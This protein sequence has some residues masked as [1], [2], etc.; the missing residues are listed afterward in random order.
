MGLIEQ[1]LLIILLPLAG[2]FL[3]GLFGRKLPRQGD[4]LATGL[5]GAS[6]ALAV[7]TFVQVTLQHDPFAGARTSG[8]WLRFAPAEALSIGI[9]VDN[10]TA[11]MLVVVGVVSFLVHLYSMGYMHG[12]PKYVRFYTVLQLFTASM[13]GLVL[14]DNL[15][16]LYVSWELMGL[17]S[18]LLIGHYFEKPSAAWACLKA[19]MTTR[20]G[21]VLMFVGILILFLHVGS[22]R[23]AD[24]FAAV[25]DGRLAGSAQMW[26]GLLLFGG[27][28]GK[29]AQFPLHIWL[30]DAME[31]PTPV[32]ALIHAATMVAAGVYLMARTYLLLSAETFLVVAYVGGFTAIFAASIGLVMD[33]IKKVLAYSTVSQ[34]GYMMLGLGVGGFVVTGYTAGVY[35]LTTHAFF[36]AGLFL[37]AGSIIHA[38]HTQSLAQMGGLRRKMPVTFITFLIATLALT[39][40]W[41]LSGFYSKDAI[42]AS[43][44][45]FA[46]RHPEHLALPIF[47]VL[48]AA[49][50]AFYMFRLVFLAFFGDPR[51][52]H[53]HSHAHESP[54]VMTFP[55]L[56]LAA[57]SLPPV[58]GGHGNWFWIGNPVP[59]RG[60]VAQRYGVATAEQGQAKV[61]TEHGQPV[62]TTEGGVAHGEHPAADDPARRAHTM[63]IGASVTVLLI[64]FVLA[65]LIYIR[66]VVDPRALAC[67]F[68][69]IHR[70]LVNKYYIDEIVQAGVIR[71]VMALCRLV[72]RA[73][74]WIVDGLVNLTALVTRAIAWVTGRA[75][76]HVVDGVVNGVADSAMTAGKALGRLQTGQVGTYLTGGV[77]GV[78]ML[79]GFV[80]WVLAR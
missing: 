75:D 58:G 55:L 39:G 41:P 43:A 1:G 29:S 45:E 3:V 73:D 47:A 46:L 4:W 79:A 36:K 65:W 53:A 44:I 2:F 24:I 15:L 70:L 72:A 35:H 80:F 42:I 51:D 26:A 68:A 59:L 48:A 9:M 57:L 40:L 27:A 33:D 28:M 74:L 37:G 19:F 6:L 38:V 20:V 76:S 31:G 71:P 78:V 63:A 5:V 10:L 66:R 21:D 64:G 67:R 17:S 69:P 22:L 23:F 16:T 56:V 34:L 13:F 18:Y 61:S 7:K 62:L 77:V 30:P 12:D 32:S 8:P 11:S 14:S 25:A 50:T 60:E 52:A 49:M 54:L